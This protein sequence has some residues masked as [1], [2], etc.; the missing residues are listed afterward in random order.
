MKTKLLAMMILAGGSM[1]AQTRFSA[2][3]EF[4]GSGVGFNAPPPA[5]A[6]EMPP[7]PGPDFTWVDGYWSQNYGRSV[8]T[9]GFWNRQPFYNGYRGSPGFDNR[10]RDDRDHRG[11]AGGF[12][13]DRNRGFE[14]HGVDRSRPSQNGGNHGGSNG[15]D[16]RSRGGFR[17]R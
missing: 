5:Y 3:V 14:N 10:F 2:G 6:T 4:G 15:H 8:W 9:P 16:N 17:G 13:A 7:C 12:A 11:F 1:F